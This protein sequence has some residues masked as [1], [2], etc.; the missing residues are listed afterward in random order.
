MA[1][2]L[3]SSLLSLD[4]VRASTTLSKSAIYE[5]MAEGSFPRPVKISG[6]RV[7]WKAETIQAWI[8]SLLS[9]SAIA[10]TSNV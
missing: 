1:A 5:L 7:A 8:N 9:T 10:E 4:A 2:S 6:R 3:I